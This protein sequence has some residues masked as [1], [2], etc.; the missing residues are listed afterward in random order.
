MLSLAVTV[1]VVGCSSNALPVGDASQT[2]AVCYSTPGELLAV[3][4]RC[5]GRTADGLECHMCRDYAGCIVGRGEA[6]DYCVSANYN[7]ADPACSY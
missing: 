6:A 7:C 4:R 3:Y 5:A 1:I 2:L